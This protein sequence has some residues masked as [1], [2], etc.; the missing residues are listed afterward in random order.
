MAK[1]FSKQ[2]TISDNPKWLE[3][4]PVT[5]YDVNLH[6]E[7]NKVKYG[8]GVNQTAVLNVGMVVWFRE[9]NLHDIFFKNE[10]GASVGKVSVVGIYDVEGGK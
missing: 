4:A 3:D 2:Y 7:D 1:V 6:V 5:L 9:L 10:T 8:N